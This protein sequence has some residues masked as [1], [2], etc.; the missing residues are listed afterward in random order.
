M[1]ECARLD[2]LRMRQFI[3]RIA[4][5]PISRK[6]FMPMMRLMT[7]NVFG[8]PAGFKQTIT[9]STNESISF[10]IFECPYQKWCRKFGE[11][12]LTK[13]FCDADHHT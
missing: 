3:D 2:A 9:Q 7:K 11:P 5:N 8:K 4:S 1:D 6:V 13:N 12:E 10:D